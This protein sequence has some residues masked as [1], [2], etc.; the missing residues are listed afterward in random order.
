MSGPVRG[1]GRSP[2]YRGTVTACHSLGLLDAFC[3]A[4]TWDGLFLFEALTGV[5]FGVRTAET[6]VNRLL[7]PWIDPDRGLDVALDTLGLPY[8]VEAWPPDA[9]ADAP[10]GLLRRWLAEGVVV[11]GPLDMS[12]LPHLFHAEL[13]R[14]CDHY[15]VA[16]AMEEG[17]LAIRDSEGWDMAWIACD[18][19]VKAW[20]GDDVVEG[21]G[22]FVMR[23]LLPAASRH[24]APRFHPD[25]RAVRRGL[26]RAALLL[27]E[28]A[29]DPLGGPNAYARLAGRS[30]EISAWPAARRSLGY[31]LPTRIQRNLCA[32]ALLERAAAELPGAVDALDTARSLI[33]R[34][35]ELLA[36]CCAAVSTGAVST[37]AAASLSALHDAAELE[38]RLTDVF[39]TLKESACAADSSI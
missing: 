21:R 1:P 16:L 7:A 8:E 32:L 20:R 2:P 17:R 30:A 26:D 13:F 18:D 9:G 12:G 3:S 24:P 31:L 14:G 6:D 37:G 25:G 4:P 15:V 33:G 27:E 36:R 39:R 23:R 19:L 22:A 5:P 38:H 35:S 11:L 28:S 10:L 29:A 34:Q